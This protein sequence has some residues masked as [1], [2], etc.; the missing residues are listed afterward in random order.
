MAGSGCRSENCKAE[1]V[2]TKLYSAVRAGSGERLDDA[3]AGV[4]DYPWKERNSDG[5]EPGWSLF[6]L[7]SEHMEIR[8]KIRETKV[9]SA[10]LDEVNARIDYEASFHR[11]LATATEQ[12]LDACD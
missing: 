9:T 8:R 5:L 12:F 4:V 7:A 11:D 1:P 2:V 3:L 6:E 10:N